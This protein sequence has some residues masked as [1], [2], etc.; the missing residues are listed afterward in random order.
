MRLLLIEDNAELA[1]LLAQQLAPRGF[2]ADFARTGREALEMLD[3][4]TYAAAVL[5]LGLP[6]L[7]GLEVLKGLRQRQPNL[8]VLVLTAR[9]Q[10]AD[11]VT[12]LEAGADDYLVKPFAYEEVAAR[13]AALLRRQGQVGG[14]QLQLAN[15]T[16]DTR[17][18]QVEVDG[19]PQVLSAQELNLLEILMRR[20][21]RV[22][23]K[24]HLDDQLFGLSSDVGPNAV[25]V[26]VYR[27][28]KRLQAAHA[29][30]EIHTIRGV[31]YLLAAATAPASACGA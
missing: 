3:L 5:D 16:L 8:P 27:L 28:R 9:G 18:R 12:G 13:L 2:E 30:V 26:A 31:G 24:R 23:P 19:A 15:L 17:F 6:D 10:V 20:A 25:E 22:V 7:D 4:V 1:E 21:G 29:A 11:R 14:E